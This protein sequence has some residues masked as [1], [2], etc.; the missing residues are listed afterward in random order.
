M[1][2]PR[3]VLLFR[4]L[5]AD[6]TIGK[7]L[8]SYILAVDLILRVH[9]HN[10]SHPINIDISSFLQNLYIIEGAPRLGVKS[11]SNGADRII[12]SMS[13]SVGSKVLQ[14]L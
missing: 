12:Q 10:T 6:F 4:Y 3:S 1:I 7:D 14:H 5:I 11:K 2:F 9:Q 13:F 8:S